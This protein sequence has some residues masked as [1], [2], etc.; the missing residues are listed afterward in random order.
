MEYMTI[1][2]LAEDQHVTYEAIRRQLS[3]YRKELEGHI[4]QKK[5]MKLLD[6]YAV[7]FLRQRRRQSPVVVYNQDREETIDALKNELLKAQNMITQL[8]QQLDGLKDQ[9]RNMIEMET[10]YQLSLEQI[11]QKD[12]FLKQAEQRA[13]DARA[14]A[15]AA[16]TALVVEREKLFKANADLQIAQAERDRLE[17][18][19]NS[20]QKSIF[21]FYRKKG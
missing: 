10:K 16:Q 7:D 9:R 2:Q 17:K 20:Y 5:N 15:H 12:Q 3:I 19:A 4:I 8:Q 14:E 21:G 18:E 13:D 11:E 1:R 6:E